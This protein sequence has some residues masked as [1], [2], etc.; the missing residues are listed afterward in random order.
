MTINWPPKSDVAGK[1]CPQ[2]LSKS[3]RERDFPARD[4]VEIG[5]YGGRG[6]VRDDGEI[7]AE[8]LLGVFLGDGS[9]FQANKAY[10]EGP[11][12]PHLALPSTFVCPPRP[13][14][15]LPPFFF[16]IRWVTHAA[17][18]SSSFEVASASAAR[19]S[20]RA[21]PPHGPNKR[22]ICRAAG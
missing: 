5:E 1:D 13:A 15:F 16:A 9:H 20:R 4:S 22:H 12:S 10:S 18:S 8:S 14:S 7:D 21:T 2:L 3:S 17:K 19:T 6:P 11:W